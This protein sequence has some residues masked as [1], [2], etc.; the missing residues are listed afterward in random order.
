MKKITLLFISIG[1]FAFGQ[2]TV[3]FE[4][5][6]TGASWTWTVDDNGTDPALELLLIPIQQD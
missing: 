2:T 1:V 4:P 3:D 5:G 6:G